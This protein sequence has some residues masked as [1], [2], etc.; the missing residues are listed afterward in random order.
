VRQ[1]DRAAQ[2]VAEMKAAIESMTVKAPRAGTVVYVTD[3]DDNKKK[4][5]DQTWRGQS[6]IE[7]PDLQSM[8]AVGEIDE[9]DAGRVAVGQRVQFHLDAHPDV[10]FAGRVRSIGTAVR[11]RSEQNPNKVVKVSIDLDR[12]DPQRMRPG[13]RLVGT[14]EIER[15]PGAVVAPSEA[16]FSRPD[17]AVSYRREGFGTRAVRP[18]VGKR[19]DR[20]VQIVSGLKP[21]DRVSRR[22]LGTD[23]S[24]GGSAKGGGA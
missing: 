20:W 1:R 2:R 23:A 13:M 12:T 3:W 22:D 5:G 15:L 8:R 4:V 16:V 9:A 19:N 21:G 17:G 11:G 6:V 24:G 10:T 14:V 18:K 7:I